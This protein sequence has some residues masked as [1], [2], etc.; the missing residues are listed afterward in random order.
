MIA[1]LIILSLWVAFV[2]ICDPDGFDG[3][4]KKAAVSKSPT[5]PGPR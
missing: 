4:E 3:A 1:T 5:R 2:W